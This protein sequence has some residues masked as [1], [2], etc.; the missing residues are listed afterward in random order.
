MKCEI[1]TI[2][3][4]ILLG[5]TLDT[6]SSWI[7][8]ELMKMG[9]QVYYKST[10]SDKEDVILEALNK[11]EKQSDLIIV[12][13]GLGPTKDDLTKQTICK[14]FNTELKRNEEVY[15][16][17][18]QRWKDMGRK[19]NQL[20]ERQ[21]DLPLSSTILPNEWGTASG[22]MF[23]KG[24][25]IFVFFPGVPIEMKN[26][27]SHYF[28]PILLKY[29]DLEYFDYRDIHTIGIAESK[30]AKLIENIEEDLPNAISIAY[31]PSLGK[32]IV[33]LYIRKKIS[34]SI[35]DDILN[36]IK[37]TLGNAVI[38]N[39][40]L[41]LELW[42]QK[43]LSAKHKMIGTA[44]S[45]TGGL[46]ASKVIKWAGSSSIFK[47]SIVAY[48]DEIKINKL[49]VSSS[50]IDRYGA[51]SKE[52][53]E[54]MLDGLIEHFGVDFGISVSGIA[55]PG[56]GTYDKPVG[57]VWICVGSKKNKLSKCFKLK[58]DRE[59]NI[60]LSATIALNQLRKFIL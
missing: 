6:N 30:I 45:C 34:Y 12:T 14:F 26:I 8:Q 46:I 24:K 25:T 35:L 4:E 36:Q 44:E 31:L 3:D 1:I 40:D 55:G 37:E 15:N 59:Q 60:E 20:N 33:R 22:L 43:E 2:G 32:V 19:M 49:N 11:A 28:S 57:T 39:G 29:T 13:G 42:L 38:G 54:L 17:L 18:N 5:K 41:P 56:G 21:A 9:V 23:E 50:I 27:F 16:R 51:V 53:V 47:G 10:I 52:V 48:S 7:A 58:G